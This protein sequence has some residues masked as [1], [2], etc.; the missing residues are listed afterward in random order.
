MID[1]PIPVIKGAMDSFCQLISSTQNYKAD[2]AKTK[3]LSEIKTME[4]NLERMELRL[5]EKN[6]LAQFELE[7]LNVKRDILN[8]FLN[9]AKHV[10]DKKTDFFITEYHR[11]TGLLEQHIQI[12]TLE[13]NELDDKKFESFGKIEK[14]KLISKVSKARREINHSKVLLIKAKRDIDKHIINIT[15]Q[16]VEVSTRW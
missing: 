2:M 3:L 8:S 7:K 9:A 11:T 10:F 16:P 4:Y 15:I 14:T 1:L 13:L 6:M 12:L 5:A